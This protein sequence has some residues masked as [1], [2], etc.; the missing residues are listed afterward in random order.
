MI[1]KYLTGVKQSSPFGDAERS[2]V[3]MF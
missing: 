3:S 1:S 2:V